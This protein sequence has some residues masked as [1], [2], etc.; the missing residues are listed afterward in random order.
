VTPAFRVV[1]WQAGG[2]YTGQTTNA[3]LILILKATSCHISFERGLQGT[4]ITRRTGILQ[5]CQSQPRCDVFC[6]GIRTRVDNAIAH[7]P[8]FTLYYYFKTLFGCRLHQSVCGETDVSQCLTIIDQTILF[9]F[10][11]HPLAHPDALSA[12]L[13]VRRTGET[14]LLNVDVRRNYLLKRHLM[15]SNCGVVWKA[16]SKTN[17]SPRTSIHTS[18]SEC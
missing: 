16:E 14:D 4:V 8:L 1:E 15:Q 9:C 6:N 13:L 12:A 3:C 5:E 11:P 2:H 10:L 7:Y 18:S 17:V